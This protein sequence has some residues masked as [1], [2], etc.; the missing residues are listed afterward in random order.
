[1]QD[2]D[3]TQALE[4]DHAGSDV[5]LTPTAKSGVGRWWLS[6]SLRVGTYLASASRRC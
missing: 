6:E 1:M 4:N 2:H 3:E 5:K